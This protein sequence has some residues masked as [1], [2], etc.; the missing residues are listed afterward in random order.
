MVAETG[1][2]HPRE[3]FVWSIRKKQ[4]HGTAM[5][6]QQVISLAA[7]EVLYLTVAFLCRQKA[8]TL[9]W[10]GPPLF[11]WQRREQTIIKD[12]EK[13]TSMQQKKESRSVNCNV[14]TL[15]VMQTHSVRISWFAEHFG[16]NVALDFC[17]IVFFF[18]E[19][20][21]VD[22]RFCHL[23]Y[24]LVVCNACTLFYVS[25]SEFFFLLVFV[26]GTYYWKPTKEGWNKYRSLDL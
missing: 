23:C 19:L 25:C 7:A 20:F 10:S 12:K 26:Y 8:N 3:N 13:N 5:S 17:L 4:W 15:T 1:R 14:K 6:H 2:S 24:M 18:I 9:I 22:G 11:S 16:C 21:S